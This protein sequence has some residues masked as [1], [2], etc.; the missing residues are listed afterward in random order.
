MGRPPV[1]IFKGQMRLSTI[2]VFSLWN[3]SC[4]AQGLPEARQC[5]K[6]NWEL[7]LIPIAR[8]RDL[9]GQHPDKVKTSGE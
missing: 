7:H 2:P 1:P 5:Q 9:S 6:G 3:R 4:P 8:I